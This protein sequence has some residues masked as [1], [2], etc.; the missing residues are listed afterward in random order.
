MGHRVDDR[1][2][3]HRHRVLGGLRAGEPLD[4]HS[5]ADI[6]INE[7]LG[8][9][10]L[11]GQRA[12]GIVAQKFVAHLRA[13]V[14]HQGDLRV[15]QETLRLAAE[16]EDAGVGGGQVARGWSEGERGGGGAG[17]RGSGAGR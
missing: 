12:A 6:G 7:R 16:K 9:A 11:V 8:L 2:P 1:L 5:P 4:V 15:A 10:D 14:A 17:E 3:D 13:R